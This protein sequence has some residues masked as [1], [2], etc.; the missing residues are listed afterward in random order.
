MKKNVILLLLVICILITSPLFAGGSNAGSA[1][2]STNGPTPIS[3][4]KATGRRTWDPSLPNIQEV[5]RRTNTILDVVMSDA[6]DAR[7]LLFASNDLPDLIEFNGLEFQNY[8]STGYLRPLDDLLKTNGPNL[9]KNHTQD[10]WD[11]VTIQNKIY[12]FPYENLRVKI[13]SYVRTDWLENVGIDLSKNKDYGNIG[14][15]VITLDEYRDILIAF[16]RNDPDRNGRNDTYGMGATG[17]KN[18]GGWAGIY[19]A[20]GGIPGQYYITNNTAMPWIVTDQYRQALVYINSLWREGVIDPEIY[21]NNNDQAKQKMINSVSGSAVGEWW[22]Q[23]HLLQIDG[24]QNLVPEADFIPLLLTSNDGKLF[25]PPDNGLITNTLSISTM[26]KNPVKVMDFM[27]LMNTDELWYLNWYGIEGLDYT[28]AGPNQ[29]VR[30]EIGLTK[31]NNMV[32]DPIYT[33]SNRLD[34]NRQVDQNAPVTSWADTVRIKW[35]LE[36][37]VPQD[38]IYTSAF[39]GLPNPQAYIDYGVDVNNW[40]EQSAMAFITGETPINDANW[41]NY[42]NT[43]KRMGG[44]KILQGFIDTYNNLKGTRVTAGITE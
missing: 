33:L 39:Y 28:L 36:S 24:L 7:N 11:L 34:I 12:A 35:A 23:A 44:V 22:S 41:N 20:F 37:Y 25:G 19:G 42:I 30:T 27:D 6:A 32:V 43:W 3:I 15:K 21:L 17:Q 8:L 13:F 29:P 1:S 4:F 31:Y 26:S 2:T 40:I 18:N 16:T 10:A 38:N 5:M 14:G 9:L